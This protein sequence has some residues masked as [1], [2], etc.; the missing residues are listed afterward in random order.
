[1][2]AINKGV[3]LKVNNKDYILTNMI[4][5]ALLANEGNSGGVVFTVKKNVAGIV[6][7][8]NKEEGHMYYVKANLINKY[9]GLTI[10]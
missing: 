10:Y 1:M 7:S 2:T 4:K 8:G 3:Y 6:Q 9:Y 5:V